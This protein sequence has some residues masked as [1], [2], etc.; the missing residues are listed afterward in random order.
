MAEKAVTPFTLCLALT[1]DE[2]TGANRDAARLF[3]YDDVRAFLKRLLSAARYEW[4]KAGGLVPKIRFLCA[5]EQGSRTDRCHWHLILFSNIDLRDLGR[6]TYF[7]NLVTDKEKMMSGIGKKANKVRLHWSLWG[8]G[9]V[10]FQEADQGG[11]AYVLSYCLKDQFTH[12]K[13]EGTMREAKAENFATGLFRMSKKPSIGEAWF[14]AKMERLHEAGAVLPNLQLMVPGRKVPWEPSGE[15]RK[16]LLW[17]LVALN[18]AVLWKTGKDAPQWSAL[19]R[20]C[21]ENEFDRRILDGKIWYEKAQAERDAFAAL[22]QRAAASGREFALTERRRKCGRRVPCPECCNSLSAGI[23]NSLGL[24]RVESEAGD[25]GYESLA[26]V[27]LSQIG[28]DQAD[29]AGGVNPYCSEKSSKQARLAFFGR[30]KARN[31]VAR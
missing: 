10:S 6:V 17:S 7:G 9:F 4:K 29:R 30:E 3:C 5:G 21:E 26:G 13:S 11:M 2:E 18:K 28:N 14:Q 16:R 31:S 22:K 24:V 1:Y 19:V 15:W 8:R 27:P 25:W 23:L 20:S 12:E